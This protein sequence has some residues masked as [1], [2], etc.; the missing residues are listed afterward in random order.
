MTDAQSATAKPL[1]HERARALF[2]HFYALMN[3]RDP[4][5]IPT[6]FTEDIEFQDDAWPETMKGYA[7]VER[8]FTALWRAVPDLRFELVEGPYLAEDGRRAAARVRIDGTMTGSADP[9]G[10]CADGHSVDD[11]VRRLLRAGRRA[12]Q[13]RAGDREHERCGDPDGHGARSR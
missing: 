10:F 13:A 12:H 8:F 3:E 9:P 11:G 5:H 7:E 1:S 6:I 4:R 2:E